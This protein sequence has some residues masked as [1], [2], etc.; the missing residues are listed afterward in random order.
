MM[1]NPVAK[2]AAALDERGPSGWANRIDCD[3]LDIAC[4]SHC[5]LGQVY[6]AYSTGMT[7][8][9]GLASPIS[10][11]DMLA[12]D[13]NGRA[14]GFLGTTYWPEPR[15]EAEWRRIITERRQASVASA[16][17]GEPELVGV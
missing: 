13:N 10:I 16:P 8:L 15:L 7:R 17:D 11:T 6:G 3:R 1:D 2:G 14:H 9:F 4:A 12:R 5:V